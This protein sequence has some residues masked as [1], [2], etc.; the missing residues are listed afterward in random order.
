MSNRL[1]DQGMF[2]PTTE[3]FEAT[4]TEE[5][6]KQIANV[7]NAHALVINQKDSGFYETDTPQGGSAAN[8]LSFV[9]GQ[10]FFPNPTP[11]SGQPNNIRRDVFRKVINFG[12]LPNATTKSVAHNITVN[13]NYSFTRI[14][15]TAT[16]PTAGA[17]AVRFIPLPYSST[18]ALTNNIEL[19]LTNTNVSI[20]TGINRSAF[21]LCYVV[22]EWIVS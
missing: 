16:N 7:I 15:G 4:D 22:L 10:T 5:L 13:S 8:P 17:G 11:L 9:S 12:A 18:A 21:T 20:R 3:T 1:G 19:W 2:L 14:Y 6:N